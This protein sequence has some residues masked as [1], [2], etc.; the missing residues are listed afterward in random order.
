MMEFLSMVLHADA[1]LPQLID[2][3]IQLAYLV[4]FIVIFLQIGVLPFF[5]LPSNPFLFVAGALWAAAAHN[6]FLLMALM[7][8]A[9]IL[10]NVTAYFLGNTVGHAFFIRYLHWPN[11]AALNKTHAFFEQHGEKGFLF[12]LFVPVVRTVTPFLAGM[13]KMHRMKF[14]KSASFGAGIWVCTCALSGY[15]F[16]NI[17]IVKN[18]LGLITVLGLAFVIV[19]AIFKKT[20]THVFQSKIK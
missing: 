9:A 5:F 8:V 13:T 14:L 15:F 1:M 20:L 3:H 12:S 16:G 6:P 18:H 11:Q 19:A 7:M 2:T 10:G 17:P 4:V